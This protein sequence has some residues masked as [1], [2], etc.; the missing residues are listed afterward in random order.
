MRPVLLLASCAAL[1]ACRTSDLGS[2]AS[3]A[4]CSATAMCDAVQRV[5]VETNAP[6]I[7][8]V[9]VTTAAAYTDPGGKTY[10][11]TAGG[12]LAVTATISSRGGV[13][14]DAASACLRL[15]SEAGPCGHPGTAGSAG[16]FTFAL[17]RLPGPADGTALGFQISAANT[18]GR[19]SI[20]PVQQ[21]YFDD[22]P[23]GISVIDDPGVYARTLPD[24]GVAPI[25]VQATIA[26]GSGVV[27]PLLVSAGKSVPPASVA[28]GVYL[29]PLDPSDAPPG[30]EGAYAFQI[31]AH[32]NLGHAA[33]ASASRRIDDAPPSISVQI[34]KDA[35]DGGGVTY[36]APVANTGWTG[37]TFVYSDVV[38]VS[39][40]ISDLSGVAS[41]TLR[42]DGLELDGGVATGATRSLG[43]AAGTTSCA[44][45][46]DVTL[47]DA[48]VPFHT[49]ASTY[50]AGTAIGLVPAG[51]LHFT[52]DAQDGAR[53][54]DG[55]AS[56]KG[57]TSPTSARTTRLLWD[58]TLAGTAVS[59]IAVH[60]SG[61]VIVTMDGGTGDTVYDLAPD[62]PVTRWS[63]GSDAGQTGGQAQPVGGV[64][65]TPAIGA[66]D[67][68]AARIYV[69]SGSGNLYAI[70]PDGSQA[71]GDIT[72]STLF[73]VGPA[74]TQVT[75]GLSTVDQIVVP[76]GVGGGGSQLW[77]AT[78]D[79]DVT[80][81][82]SSNR[83][84][85]AAPLIVGGNVYFATQNLGGTTTHLTRHPIAGNGALGA[86]VTSNANPGAPFF[87]PITDGTNV[88]AATRPPTGGGEV[89]AIGPAFISTTGTLW[90]T[91]LTTAGL[92][93]DPTF[94]I[95]GRIYGADLANAV[96]TF[97][98]ATG[99]K[100]TFLT[101]SGSGTPGL[102]PLHG[103]DGHIYTPR[104][105]SVTQPSGFEAYEGDQLSW[106][107]TT[108][109]AKVILRYAMID[110]AGRVFVAAGPTVYAFLS[111]DHGLADTPWP[112]LRRDG[113]N[114]GNA[115]ALPY[116]IRTVSGCAQ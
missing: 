5:C 2:C 37:A 9:A 70:D 29:F 7:A 4:D 12:A 79:T 84:F 89:D 38:H 35:P 58:S 61:D 105:P 21:V 50:D 72:P 57:A 116:G 17:P 95:D 69:A 41:A 53:A 102:T 13:P 51:D 90:T 56:A 28:S 111:D 97:D 63:F 104:R 83:D 112:T 66:G 15:T 96:L 14:V 26:D 55:T 44:F 36:P 100:A 47:N 46:L 34:Y 114:T 107:F 65:G 110:C 3:D 115:S 113:R 45:S 86:A 27:S 60:P 52:I 103:S 85:F 31:T 76:D 22:Q 82:A 49:G 39:G 68:S 108:P 75:I 62:Q 16:S 10:F 88:Y 91:T 93:G 77:R 42:V 25:N 24:G 33:Q 64:I 11:D 18:S 48:G 99:A 67:A 1:A 19:S 23:P 80:S 43:C 87:G 74:V 98:A 40:T 71:W 59:G 78:S 54:F 20:S 106:T 92:A 8:N 109:I 94:G 6:Q 73:A 101:L 30:A 81:V 32:D